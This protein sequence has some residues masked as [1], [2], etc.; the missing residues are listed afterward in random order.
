LQQQNGLHANADPLLQRQNGLHANADPLWQQQNA[1]PANADPLLQRNGLHIGA[2]A[3]RG[4]GLF[5]RGNGGPIT[6][7]RPFNAGQQV[8][9]VEPLMGVGLIDVDDVIC[10]QANMLHP[11]GV[12]ITNVVAGSPAD[13]AGLQRGDILVRI[14]GRKILNIVSLNKLLSSQN[15]GRKFELVYI[16][17]GSRQTTK[18]KTGIKNQASM[19]VAQQNQLSAQTQQPPGVYQW[20]L[21]AS[22]TPI[23]PA[24]ATFTRTGV[25]VQNAGGIL[26]ANGLRS[27]DIIKGINGNQVEDMQSFVKQSKKVDSKK[28]FLLDVIRSGNSIYLTVKG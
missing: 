9:Y 18:I 7:S 2:G 11:E 22:I 19:P 17:N 16:R 27:G 5:G 28:G 23:L 8:A 14:A 1:M 12:L 13:N 3:G 4:R 15:I 21:G 26:A 10:K 25:Y 6:G 24:F 20:P